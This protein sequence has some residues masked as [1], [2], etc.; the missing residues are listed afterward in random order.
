M[1]AIYQD[2][3]DISNHRENQILKLCG[4][5]IRFRAPVIIFFWLILRNLANRPSFYVKI[6]EFF[7]NIL[8]D[9]SEFVKI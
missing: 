6:L 8:R 7:V 5:K 4:S 1:I 2:K 9:F 3:D